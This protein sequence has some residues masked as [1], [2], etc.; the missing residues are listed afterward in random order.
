M[1]IKD[2]SIE[3][4]QN[5]LKPIMK[6]NS[7]VDMN[8]SEQ[9]ERLSKKSKSSSFKSS[10]KRPNTS[11]ATFTNTYESD[12]EKYEWKNLQDDPNKPK[13]MSKASLRAK[14][15]ADNRYKDLVESMNSVYIPS[16]TT[17]LNKKP[18]ERVRTLIRSN[19]ALQGVGW[20]GDNA[21][22]K[23]SRFEIEMNKKLFEKLISNLF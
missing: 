9:D 17:D 13:I 22:E 2:E 5:T 11:L 23:P 3:D 14:P 18:D 4:F 8:L 7:V 15:T 21:V 20:N 10:L 12:N 6:A 1:S 19:K 16:K